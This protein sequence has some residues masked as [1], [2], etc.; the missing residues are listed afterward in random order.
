MHNS[1]RCNSSI[2]SYRQPETGRPID[3]ESR[4][5]L[6]VNRAA[7]SFPGRCVTIRWNYG[8]LRRFNR[9]LPRWRLYM[10]IDLSPSERLAHLAAIRDAL[11]DQD[12]P[13]ISKRLTSSTACI[14]RSP[15]SL[16]I[17][18]PTWKTLR[19]ADSSRKPSSPWRNWTGTRPNSLCWQAGSLSKLSGSRRSLTTPTRSGV[20]SGENRGCLLTRL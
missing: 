20:P 6:I 8:T 5:V 7:K 13:R 9:P 18:Q 14:W 4:Y 2:I 1:L 12:A 10:P 11:H 15:R 19:T 16:A 17:G 3:N